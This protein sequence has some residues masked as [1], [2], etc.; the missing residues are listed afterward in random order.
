VTPLEA[1]DYIFGVVK[2][3]WDTTGG[4]KMIWTD[5]AGVPPT[6]EA[7]WGRTHL[8]HAAGGQA[9]FTDQLQRRWTA[10]GIVFVEIFAPVGDGAKK[11]YDLAE[12]VQ[13]GFR[14][15]KNDWLWFRE[16]RIDEKG[17]DGAFVRVDVR[18]VFSYDHFE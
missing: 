6:T 10:E 13:Q 14:T 7:A 1:R 16:P 2:S 9:S 18:A 15:A 11:A 5:V 8:K 17:T 12:K 3:V 4:L